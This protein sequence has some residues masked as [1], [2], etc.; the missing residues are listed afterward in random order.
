MRL[1]KDFHMRLFIKSRMSVCFSLLWVFGLFL[2]LAVYEWPLKT[3]EIRM[4]ASEDGKGESLVLRS[5]AL[6]GREVTSTIIHSVELTPVIDIYRVQQG[7]IWAWREKIRSHNAGL[8]SIKPERGRFYSEGSWMIVQ[9]GGSW[10]TINYRVGTE[11][12]GRNVLCV[13]MEPCREL[14][15]ELP[16]RRL[17]MRVVP[18]EML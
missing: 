8:P 2:A 11:Q 15:R 5:P 17:T 9:G 18:A 6:L 13:F 4:A 14:W 7:R 1:E 12:L 3:L 16:G 10:E